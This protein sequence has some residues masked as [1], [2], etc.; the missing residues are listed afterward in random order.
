MTAV[1]ETA[2]PTE[3]RP[4]GY[5][6]EP[7]DPKGTEK[8]YCTPRHKRKAAD[9]RRKGSDPAR[10]AERT[11]SCPWC[12]AQ[13][14]TRVEDQVFCGKGHRSRAMEC[15]RRRGFLTILAALAAVA[16]TDGQYEPYRCARATGATHWHLRPARHPSVPASVDLITDGDGT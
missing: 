3:T 6:R 10:P 13:F 4:C 14:A 7:F 16:E 9:R 8:Q 5:C 11:A 12:G 15:E 2:A 1:D